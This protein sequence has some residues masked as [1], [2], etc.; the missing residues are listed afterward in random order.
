MD[1]FLLEMSYILYL[2]WFGD[3]LDLLFRYWDQAH[4]SCIYR[5]SE[6]PVPKHQIQNGQVDVVAGVEVGEQQKF[7]QAAARQ[8]QCA[9]A[10]RQKRMNSATFWFK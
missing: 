4:Q 6:S 3:E 7:K 5:D 9:A 8:C 2:L 10:S 1:E